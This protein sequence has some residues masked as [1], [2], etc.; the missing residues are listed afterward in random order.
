[1]KKINFF[2]FA[3]V[4]ALSISCVGIEDTEFENQEQGMGTLTI[5]VETADGPSTKAYTT[6]LGYESKL[7]NVQVLVF[8]KNTGN[9]VHY[10]DIG[11]ENSA[12]ASLSLGFK[13]YYVVANGPDLSSITTLA[14]LKSTSI[15]LGDNS[16]N[17]AEGFVMTGYGEAN[18]MRSSTVTASVTISRL[19]SRVAVTKIENALPKVYADMTIDYI[20]LSNVVANQNLNG[21]EGIKSWVNT[22]ARVSENEYIDSAEDAAYADLTF[23][24]SGKEIGNMASDETKYHLYAFPNSYKNPTNG[25]YKTQ[26]PGGGTKL[27]V[28]ATINDKRY[29]YP[30][31]MDD[32]LERNKAY[33]V[34][35]KITTLGATDPDKEIEKGALVV[36]ITPDDWKGVTYLEEI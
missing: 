10:A 24:T 25:D 3:L 7:N 16:I 32:G 4:Q 30:V 34:T 14:Q 6:A 28:A 27:V 17:E 13:T 20:L 5:N 19:V 23:K 35:L 21:D 31:N 2:I 18:I 33:E 36:N 15:T 9:L 29:Y 8:D 1:M 11:S 26:F 12:T 22:Y